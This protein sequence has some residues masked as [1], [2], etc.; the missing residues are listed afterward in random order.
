[1]KDRQIPVDLTQG[2]EINALD[3]IDVRPRCFHSIQYN[4]AHWPKD[5]SSLKNQRK[6]RGHVDRPRREFNKFFPHKKQFKIKSKY[7]D[8]F[9][10]IGKCVRKP[11]WQEE[12]KLSRLV[13][14]YWPY[15]ILQI[16]C[17]NQHQITR[18]LVIRARLYNRSLKAKLNVK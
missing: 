18:I 13:G 15:G 10:H 16:Y 11:K 7:S 12:N 17:L 1:M 8:S 5:T 6:K 2:I 4:L 3:P 14:G 9:N